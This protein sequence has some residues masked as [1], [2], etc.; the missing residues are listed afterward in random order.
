VLEREEE[1][2]GGLR[3]DV[4]LTPQALGQFE[5]L[6]PGAEVTGR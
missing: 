3:L 2:D 6:F 1:A 4:S 5:Q